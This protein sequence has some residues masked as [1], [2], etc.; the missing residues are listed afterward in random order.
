MVPAVALPGQSSWLQFLS[1]LPD[2]GSTC[3]ALIHGPLRHYGARAGG[4]WALTDDSLERVTTYGHTAAE[5]SR[6]RPHPAAPGLRH[7][8]RGEV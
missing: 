3:A 5:T 7:H 6:I 2:P 4:I 8:P 1:T